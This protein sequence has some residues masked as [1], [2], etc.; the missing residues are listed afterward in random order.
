MRASRPILVAAVTATVG[1]TVLSAA[2][3]AQLEIGRSP[4][5]EAI[6]VHVP[7]CAEPGNTKVTWAP[8]L[9][10]EATTS[11]SDPGPA[12]DSDAGATDEDTSAPSG[13][14]ASDPRHDANGEPQPTEE[15]L[16]DPDAILTPSGIEETPA[17]ES[18]TPEPAPTSPD[19]HAT[20]G[21]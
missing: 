13:S 9:S 20:G 16:E 5:A 1:L 6:T 15:G 4:V 7:T 18:G 21:L 2:S 8:A 10:C 17:E 14:T 3:A 19:A 12:A 11:D